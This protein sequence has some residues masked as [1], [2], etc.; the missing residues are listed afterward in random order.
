MFPLNIF[1]NSNSKEEIIGFTFYITKEFHFFIN[2]GIYMTS[3]NCKVKNQAK[4]KRK[5][6]LRQKDNF[7][8]IVDEVENEIKGKTNADSVT[9][10]CG[11]F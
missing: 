11:D 1:N 7:D 9:D 3:W 8:I 4:V 6:R 5:T 2:I 10:K